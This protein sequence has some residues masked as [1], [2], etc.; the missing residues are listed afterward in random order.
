MSSTRADRLLH[1]G[2][3]PHSNA[4]EVDKLLDTIRISK[5]ALID[6]GQVGSGFGGHSTQA[7]AMTI[8]MNRPTRD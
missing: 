3:Q 7:D 1:I 4:T 6:V 2:I 5:R 8:D